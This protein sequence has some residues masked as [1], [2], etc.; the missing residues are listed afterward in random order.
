MNVLRCVLTALVASAIVSI[1]SP[2]NAQNAPSSD[3][4]GAL[5]EKPTD[6]EMPTECGGSWSGESRS[7]AFQCHAGDILFVQGSARFDG[8]G[9]FVRVSASCGGVTL[10]CF[11]GRAPF[12]AACQA[13][14]V[15]AGTT[16]DDER[17][18]CIVRGLAGDSFAC[19]S[20]APQSDARD[21]ERR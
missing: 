1:P 18:S 11:G 4:P 5:S 19:G 20:A 3:T 2:A 16:F 10:E 8:R 17:G 6:G 12:Y 15:D 9:A 14:S 21:E 13:T 7:C